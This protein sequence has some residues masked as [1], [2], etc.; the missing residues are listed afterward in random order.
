VSTCPES[1]PPGTRLRCEATGPHV[2]HTV[3]R[4]NGG[5]MSWFRYDGTLHVG[6]GSPEDLLGDLERRIDDLRLSIAYARGEAD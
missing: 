5:R 4:G 1:I 3:T 2:V 6:S